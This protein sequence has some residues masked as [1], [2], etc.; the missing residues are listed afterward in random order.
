MMGLNSLFTNREQSKSMKVLILLSMAVTLSI[1]NLKGQQQQFDT[2]TLPVK[3]VIVAD[4]FVMAIGQMYVW[5]R[6]MRK[7]GDKY[8][9]PSGKEYKLKS[10]EHF[11][12]LENKRYDQGVLFF[13]RD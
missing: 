9:T 3:Q 7:I 12:F 5:I 8:F 11:G 1:A 10:D 4:G 2:I 13:R 6:P